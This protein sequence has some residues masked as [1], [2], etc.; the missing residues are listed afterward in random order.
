MKTLRSDLE[1]FDTHVLQQ[2]FREL[3]KAYSYPGIMVSAERSGRDNICDSVLHC[4]L[5]RQVSLFAE[6]GIVADIL[7]KRIQIKRM[8]A[9]YADF[10][11]YPENCLPEG[12]KPKLGSLDHP[13][14]SATIILLVNS[15]GEG[16]FQ[17]QM[18]GP[19]IRHALS[20]HC[21]DSLTKWLYLRN[22]WCC[23]FPLGVDLLLIGDRGMVAIPR[24][25][26]IDFQENE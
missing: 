5:D 11:I 20:F 21:S 2:V 19:G 13:E 17:A 1:I 22:E 24:S 7:L 25:L 12:L 18:R 14:Q 6:S 10:L 8:E 23:N 26:T 16:P 4:L 15:L 9:E 3:M